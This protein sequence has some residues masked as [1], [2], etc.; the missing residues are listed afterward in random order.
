MTSA[1]LTLAHPGDQDDPDYREQL[2][3]QTA[4][5]YGQ[6][7]ADKRHNARSAFLASLPS[8]PEGRAAI[9]DRTERARRR[10]SGAE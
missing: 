10:V 3:Q 8:R 5:V 2:R 1:L 7:E 4:V 9:A 6:D